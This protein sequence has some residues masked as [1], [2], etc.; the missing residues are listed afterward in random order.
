M[1]LVIISFLILL[2][3]TVL[4]SF[5]FREPG[6]ILV[7]MGNY[8]V[9]MSLLAALIISLLVFVTLYT[10]VRFI[11]YLSRMPLKFSSAHKDYR[12]QRSQQI[13]IEGYS[14]FTQGN[15]AQSEKLF[16]NSVA[17]NDTPWLSYVSAAYAAQEQGKNVQRDEY[18]DKAYSIAPEYELAISLARAKSQISH[19]QIEQAHATLTRLNETNPQHA[20][21][22][23]LLSGLYLNMKDWNKL[24]RLLPSIRKSRSFDS[25]AMGRLEKAVYEGKLED[26]AHNSSPKQL[27]QDWKQ[28]PKKWRT[29]KKMIYLYAK[30]LRQMEQHDTAEFILR[31]A[32]NR[33]WSETLAREY[34]LVE[35]KDPTVQLMHGETWLHTNR[36]SGMLLLSLARICRR[37]KLW[38]KARIYYESS[39][40][41]TPLAETYYDLALLLDQLGE[42][43]D[44]QECYQKGLRLSV[45]GVAAPLKTRAQKYTEKFREAT[46]NDL[47]TV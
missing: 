32:L 19:G 34:G 29:D 13:L 43:G 24:Y 9:E 35:L 25:D 46:L 27:N 7:S 18:L 2:S 6:Y 16:L 1:R 3:A 5:L 28:L 22:L 36:N 41:V 10:L 38:G 11:S 21:V 23:R 20:Y 17:Y 44:A 40:S 12:R 37:A 47:V 39:L 33:S 14:Q 45:E 4:T 26:T 8:S 42:H 15:W 31:S 30:S